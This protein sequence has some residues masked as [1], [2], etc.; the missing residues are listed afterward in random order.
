MI[1]KI[2]GPGCWISNHS[3]TFGFPLEPTQ[4]DK[5]KYK[6]YFELLG[7]VLPCI[8]CRKSYKQFINE[9]DT[10]L[11]MNVVKDRQSL[12]KWFY[13]IH[14]K[15]N[16]KL[17]I[18]Y[19]VSYENIVKRYESYRATCSKDIKATGCTKPLR[20]DSYK[21]ASYR[22]CHIIPL[23]TCKKFINYALKRGIPETEFIFMAKYNKDETLRKRNCDMNSEDW[24]KRNKK[25]NEITNYMRKENIP[26]LEE[27]GEFK[28]LPTI[29]ELRLIIRLCS[30]MNNEELLKI[31]NLLK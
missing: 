5:E 22:E 20:G 12:T 10:K 19:G 13:D 7:D 14:N 29:Y 2:W 11:T 25:C 18:D 23:D 17:G 8:Y 21:M 3:I 4:E 1:T 27:D 9:P 6:N 16:K 30:N 28:G 31:T 24:V 26:S 15:V